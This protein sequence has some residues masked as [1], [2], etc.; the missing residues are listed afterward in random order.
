MLNLPIKKHSKLT[1][2]VSLSELSFCCFDRQTNSVVFV[3]EIIKTDENMRI[4]DFLEQT[5]QNYPQLLGDFDEVVILHNNI[6]STLVP[7]PFFDEKELGNYIQYNTTIFETDFFAFD[8]ILEQQMNLVY[9][10]YVNINNLFIDYYKTFNYIH[11]HS[12]LIKTILEKTKY[13]FEKKMIVHVSKQHF[14]IIV[15]QNQKLLLFNSFEYK[16]TSDFLYYILFVVEHLELRT[17]IF[18]LEFL[19]EISEF[20]YIY[21]KISQYIKNVAMFDVEYLREKNH[22]STIQNRKHFVI[23]NS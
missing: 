10:P 11:S 8:E 14:E 15:V 17:E 18:S 2:Q 1:I 20:D 5:I 21:M 7:T 16:S 4:E 19:G 13:N 23:L 12:S 6:F 3:E 22:L 9:I